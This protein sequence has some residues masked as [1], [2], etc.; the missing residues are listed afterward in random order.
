MTI[1]HIFLWASIALAS[2]G[3]ASLFLIEADTVQGR[4]TEQDEHGHGE[5]EPGDSVHI[6][7]ASAKAMGI[8]VLPAGPGK[9]RQTIS[10]TGKV[11]LNQ[12]KTAQILA[13]F[14]GVIKS[15]RKSVGE[16]VQK[17]D[18]LATIESNT[19][20]QTYS[21]TS[22]LDGVIITRN[23]SV[24]GSSGEAPIYAVADL[25]EL[26]AEFFVFSSDMDR[27]QTGQAVDVVSLNDGAS[28]ETSI[29]SLLPVAET[30]SQTVVARVAIDNE[31]EAWRAGMTVRGDVVLAEKDVALAV[32]TSAIQRQEGNSVIYIKDGETYTMRRIE[33]GQADREWTEI[34]GGVQP[35]DTYVADGSFVVKAD[36]GKSTAEHEH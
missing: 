24:G 14:Q 2:G 25:S 10:L 35:G 27:I 29:F 1:K 18:V 36:I 15:M 7:D 23:G 20:L 16:A 12:D 3:F 33:A 26:W 22:P 31:D 9:V 4:H 34:L 21:V 28:A 17:G 13:R 5:E 30:S 32:K 8:N 6:E 11:T 19:S